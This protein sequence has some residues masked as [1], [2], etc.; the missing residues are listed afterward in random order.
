MLD[1]STL[2]HPFGL[3]PIGRSGFES[4]GDFRA[5]RRHQLVEDFR[6]Q[7]FTESIPGERFRCKES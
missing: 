2:V 3:E 4:A 1:F 7:P 5:V 6:T